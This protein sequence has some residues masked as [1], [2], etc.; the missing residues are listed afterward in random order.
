MHM[1]HRL[2][3]VVA[4]VGPVHLVGPRL[5]E[6]AVVVRGHDTQALLLLL[7]G[8]LYHLEDSGADRRSTPIPKGTD[9]MNS[10]I[11]STWS[12]FSL[13]LSPASDLIV[14]VEVPLVLVLAHHPRL[15]QEEV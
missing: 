2:S 4:V 14:N 11:T 9:D 8:A 13:S 10:S 15:L 12:D 5:V 3:E 1:Y 7:V 6:V